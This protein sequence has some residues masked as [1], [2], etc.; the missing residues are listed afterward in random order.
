MI[1]LRFVITMNSVIVKPLPWSY[2]C[3]DFEQE[4][5]AIEDLIDK[6]AEINS[7]DLSTI[8]V[9]INGLRVRFSA[10]KTRTVRDYKLL[11][12]P[13]LPRLLPNCVDLIRLDGVT[14]LA[15]KKASRTSPV[16]STRPSVCLTK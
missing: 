10:S 1:Y 11:V 2:G 6:V 3:K 12:E 9:E 13:T 8:E 15:M 14:K 4:R 5:Y 7:L 16:F